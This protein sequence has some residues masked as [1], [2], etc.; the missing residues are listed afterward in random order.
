MKFISCHITP[1]VINSLGGTHTHTHTHTHTYTHTHTHILM[2]RTGLILRNQARAGL[3]PALAWFK[4]WPYSP[5]ASGSYGREGEREGGR[6]VGRPE[7]EIQ[8]S[9]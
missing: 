3:W 2:I 1:L 7:D 6:Q 9:F 8:V 4:N 5:T